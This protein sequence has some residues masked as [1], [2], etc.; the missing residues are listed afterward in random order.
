MFLLLYYHICSRFVYI[1][2]FSQ[3]YPPPPLLPLC[4]RKAVWP[5]LIY[6]TSKC[7]SLCIDLNQ[8]GNICNSCAFLYKR[9]WTRFR[10]HSVCFSS[11]I[12]PVL[13]EMLKD[14]FQ[15]Y[16][17]LDSTISLL[18]LLPVKVPFVKLIL[19]AIL[20]MGL[21]QNPESGYN[22]NLII[23]SCTWH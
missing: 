3:L 21:P 19:N 16:C 2:S 13:L 23:P 12:F 17:S 20:F 1:Y 14:L 7:A 15:L 9:T 5:F 6:L 8:L 22:L 18:S 11:F 10:A 4:S